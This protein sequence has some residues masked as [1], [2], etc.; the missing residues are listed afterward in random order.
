MADPQRLSDEDL[1][2]LI[3]SCE[4]LDDPRKIIFTGALAEL[5]S[6]RAA[7]PF[8]REIAA[9]REKWPESTNY[10]SIVEY[11]NGRRQ[12]WITAAGQIGALE[13][14]IAAAMRHFILFWK[15]AP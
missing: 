11:G 12:Y 9:L 6:L 2:L 5:R 15:D 8:E 4:R 14:T 1:E 10:V 7:Q 3:A 13:N